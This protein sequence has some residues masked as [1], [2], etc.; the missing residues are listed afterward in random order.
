MPEHLRALVVILV[1][2]TG[3]FS[4][5]IAPS[6]IPV[7]G[8]ETFA[9][10]RNLWF[11]VTL[12]AFL[13]HNF[14]IFIILA[15]IFLRQA[16]RQESNK[17]AMYFFVLFAIPNMFDKIW[18]FGILNQLFTIN[19]GRLLSLV[20]LLPAFLVLRSQ[21]D[22]LRFGKSIPDV[23]I[24]GYLVLNF[25]LVLKG[26][27][28][29]N[30]L[31]NAVLYS[32][33]EIFLPYYVASRSPKSL[34]EFR[35]ILMAFVAASMLLS[36]IGAFEFARH[37]L[38]YSSLPRALNV[39]LGGFGGYLER[40]A[41]SGVLR[42]QAS[43]S[44]IPLGYAV[45]VATLFFLYVGKYLTKPILWYMGLALLAAGV[46]APVTRGPWVGLA[47][48][49]MIFLLTA[50]STAKA[51][52]KLLLPAII[53]IPILSL[54]PLGENIISHLPF[55]GT[56]EAENVTY[57]QRLIEISLHLVLQEPFFGPSD[58]MN[59]PE[60]QELYQG[61]Q[62]MID[63]VNTYVGVGLYSGFV[64]LTLFSGFFIAVL[65]GIYHG[66]RT[67]KDRSS[68]SYLLGQV[69]LSALIGILVIIATVSSISI[70]PVVYWSVGGLG[71]AYA[72]MLSRERLL[73]RVPASG[74]SLPGRR[75]ES[76][77]QKT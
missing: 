13:A 52:A 44:T 1:L 25:F 24:A 65:A 50:P 59:S 55:V 22:T 27:T 11:G 62:G 21:P 14:W 32:F 58:Y 75:P 17:M 71:V 66:M 67:L 77:P 74:D 16:E 37:W 2:A 9:R 31:R 72:H 36:I 40:G 45:A 38:L 53:I 33:L 60:L 6:Y 7:T 39:P 23:L 63:I 41:G 54:T 35:D 68:E 57:R 70:I 19:Y 56:V 42:A 5:L 69:L 46:I 76:Q 30:T 47:V 73:A 18:G 3:V 34:K 61:S 64:G 26:S 43:V 8:K 12:S 20:I 49:L 48:M 28:L 15:A 29:T 10:R 4:F 51:I